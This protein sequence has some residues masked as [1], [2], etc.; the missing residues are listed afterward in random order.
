MLALQVQPIMQTLSRP[1]ACPSVAELMAYLRGRPH[2]AAVARSDNFSLVWCNER[3]ARGF[4]ST[5]ESLVRSTFYD[6]ASGP[7]VDERRVLM[8]KVLE[9]GKPLAYIQVWNGVRSL[10]HVYPMEA[11]DVLG[12][13]GFFVMIEPLVLPST[14]EREF[15][16]LP[17]AR[18]PH[19]GDLAML[20]RRQLEVLRLG[21]EGLTVEEMARE[22]HR[23]DKTIDNHLRELYRQLRIHNRAQL[24]R[25][26]AEHGILAFTRDQWFGLVAAA[27][28]H[29]A[30]RARNPHMNDDPA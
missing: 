26:A 24:T 17:H 6:V 22:L 11:H 2:I 23:S 3:F 10:T 5:P 13:R 12:H 29:P 19:L 21:A 4:G 30:N 28:L 15:D 20:S 18:I 25:F 16:H 14:D 7:V 9:T 1:E 27:D 8:T